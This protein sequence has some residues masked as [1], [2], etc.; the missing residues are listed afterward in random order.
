MYPLLLAKWDLPDSAT[1]PGRWDSYGR[2]FRN[3]TTDGYTPEAF[4]GDTN[5]NIE[6]QELYFNDTVA[7][8]SFFGLGDTQKVQKGSTVAPVF[9]IFT[10]DLKKVKPGVGW[11]AD[12][13]IRNDVQRLCH[14][15]RWGFTLDSVV[16]GIDAVFKEFSGFRKTAGIKFRDAQPFHCFRLNFSV[17]YNTNDCFKP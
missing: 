2:A 5:L 6:Y 9:W 14:A 11:R 13:E 16:T 15:P 8:T 1:D 17:A 3:Q 4:I 10:V 7:A 12:E